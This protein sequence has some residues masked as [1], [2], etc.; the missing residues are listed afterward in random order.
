V[1]PTFHP[2]YLLR[3]PKFKK[4]AWDDLQAVLRRL[5]REPPPVDRKRRAR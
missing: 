3:Y 2:A 1:M 5:G 4:E